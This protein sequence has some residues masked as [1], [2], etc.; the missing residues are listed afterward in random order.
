MN[1]ILQASL[2]HY[3]A[4][5]DKAIA[6]LDVYL[7]KGVGVGEHPKVVEEVINLFAKLDSANGVITTIKNLINTQ[8]QTT[9]KTVQPTE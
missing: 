9:D 1:S 8:S 7:N 2:S 5:R 4:E 3:I 6:E